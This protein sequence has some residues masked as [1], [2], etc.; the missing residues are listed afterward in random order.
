MRVIDR[1]FGLACLTVLSAPIGARAQDAAIS[2]VGTWGT[3]VNTSADI[4][5]PVAGTSPANIQLALRLDV[6]EEA[7]K[8]A[9]DVEICQ[10][11]TDSASFKVDYAKLLQYLK[12][13][14]AIPATSPA[15]GAKLGLPDLVF[16]IGIDDAGKAV[17]TDAD[18]KPGVTMPAT[19]LGALAIN[20]Y[21]GLVMTVKLDASLSAAD[22]IVGNGTFSVA[23]T[24][25]GSSFPLLSSGSINVTQKAPAAFTAKRFEGSVGCAELLPKL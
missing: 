11:T 17:D 3:K 14:I 19:A 1:L 23:G 12:T 4:V 13:E 5:V 6:R 22:T 25:F 2:L 10:L 18:T 20:A 8:L 9:A 24:I 21:T 15:I 16:K 7:G